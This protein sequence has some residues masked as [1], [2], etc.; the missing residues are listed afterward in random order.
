L[1]DAQSVSEGGGAHIYTGMKWDGDD[2]REGDAGGI[3]TGFS[4]G[5]NKRFSKGEGEKERE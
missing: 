2:G 4:D 3:P 1:L 5:I